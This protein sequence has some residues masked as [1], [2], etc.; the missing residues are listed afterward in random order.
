MGVINRLESEVRSYC[1]S[2]PVSF[3]SA[4][5]ARMRDAD[6]REYIDFFAGAGAL[7]YGHNDPRLAAS[8]VDYI[9]SD[10]ITHSLDMATEAKARFLQAIESVLLAPRKMD[11]R[12]QLPGPTGTRTSTRS[13]SSRRCSRT[14]VVVSRRPPR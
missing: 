2:F 13:T 7:N 14:T 9:T 10:G 11:Y 3:E 5:G 8:L 6:G 4:R 12:V 1:R